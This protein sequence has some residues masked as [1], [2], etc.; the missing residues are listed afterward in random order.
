MAAKGK[1]TRSG[2]Q[3]AEP[4]FDERLARLEELVR[5]MES[6]EL[7]LES[8]IERYQEGVGLLKA[9]RGVLDGYR[10]QVEELGADAESSLEPYAGDPDAGHGED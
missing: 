1:R 5:E 7:G 2:A 4:T 10:R 3:E 6:G 8:A 9:C